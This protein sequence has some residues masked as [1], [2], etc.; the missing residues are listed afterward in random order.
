MTPWKLLSARLPSILQAEVTECGLACVAM[1]ARFHGHDTDLAALRRRFAVS[2]RG[3]SLD[4]LMRMA[5][6]LDLEASPLRVDMEDL[7]QLQRPCL[8]HWDLNHFVVLASISRRHAVVHDP[9]SG[10][11]RMTLEEVAEHFTGVALELRPVA[12]FTPLADAEPVG[13]RRLIG[14]V[15]GLKT[16]LLH[17]LLL[18]VALETGA[19]LLPFQLQWT[20]DQALVAADRQLLTALGIGFLGLV[21]MQAIVG[22]ARGWLVAAFGTSMNFQWLGNVFSHLLRLP[23]EFFEKRHVGHIMSCFGAVSAIQRTLTTSLVQVV[24]DGALA[25]G[26]LAMMFMYSPSLAAISLLPVL[27]CVALRILLYRAQRAAAAR[28]IAHQ[29]RQ[30]THFLE[31]AIGIQA[32][33]LFGRA[34]ERRVGWLNIAADQ[35]RARLAGQRLSVAGQSTE[36]LLFG[37]E[38][39][40]VVWLAAVQVLDQ[41][42]T[43]GMLFAYLAYR[44]QFALRIGALI[45]KVFEI[46]MLRVHCERLADI[47]LTPAES[48]RADEIDV[49]RIEPTIELKD[50]SFRYAPSDPDV[51]RHV[52]LRIEPGECVAIAGASGGGKTTLVKLMLGVMNPSEGE[53]WVG[54]RPLQRMGLSNHRRL[55]GTVMQDDRLFSGSIADNICFFDPAPDGE[56]IQACA[57]QAAIHGDIARMPM[58]YETLVGD[59]GSGLSGGQVQ[60]VLL[61]RALYK[62]PRILLLDEATAHLDAE[63]ERVVNEAV[64]ELKLTRIIVAHRRETIE[65]ADR[66][67]VIDDGRIARDS[68]PPSATHPRKRLAA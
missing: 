58:G 51:L 1:V 61:A 27:A 4:A 28:E 53:V 39:V 45:D 47:A 65:M 34:E 8:L 26:T 43:V 20:V 6:A 29:A 46:R 49:A 42:F 14:Q 30:E 62:Q 44:E 21:L 55:I 59:H 33:K 68:G 25:A 5:R 63:T 2:R 10:I 23:M 7:A 9:A 16:A 48:D 40:V 37:I 15:G 32:V 36:T 67:I 18:G 19:V 13:I 41:R 66:V 38:R 64:R 56:R 3:A 24:L 31:T 50:V 35:F 17:L 60:R 57:S 11:R 12:N 52:S 54:G 22:A